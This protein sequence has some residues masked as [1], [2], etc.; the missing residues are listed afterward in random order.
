[1]KKSNTSFTDCLV[2]QLIRSEY[3]RSSEEA[4]V[5]Y[6]LDYIFQSLLYHA[7]LLLIGILTGHFL[8]SILYILTMGCLK[9]FTGGAHAPNAHICS[10][11]S[12]GIFI[13]TMCMA[14]HLLLI[15]SAVILVILCL[16]IFITLLL[17]PVDCKN[18]RFSMVQRYRLKRRSAITLIV[19]CI[20]VRIFFVYNKYYCLTVVLCCLSINSVNLM[21]GFLI[22]KKESSHVSEHCNL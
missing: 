14:D 11:L 15:S 21:V 22:N 19:L 5:R 4:V 6:T 12:Y 10:L 3:I 2:Q 17:S 9:Y 1:M 20:F 8:F 7:I 13:V 18:K 16:N